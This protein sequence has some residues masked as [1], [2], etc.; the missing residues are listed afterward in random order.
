MI[1]FVLGIQA[2]KFK[3]F[4]DLVHIRRAE[5]K[6]HA[7][8]VLDILVRYITG[9]LGDKVNGSVHRTTGTNQLVCQR[10]ALCHIEERPCFI[11]TNHLEDTSIRMDEVQR[12]GGND[13][14]HGDR[15]HFDGGIVRRRGVLVRQNQIGNLNDVKLLFKADSLLH[16]AVGEQQVSKVIVRERFD[17]ICNRKRVFR[18]I[19]PQRVNDTEQ[20]ARFAIGYGT[21]R[22]S[23]DRKQLA[24]TRGNAREESQHIKRKAFCVLGFPHDD[25]RVK[26]TLVF[27]VRGQIYNV[28]LV[29]DLRQLLFPKTAF[30][31]RVKDKSLCAVQ[32]SVVSKQVERQRFTAAQRAEERTRQRIG[33]RTLNALCRPC[34]LNID[35]LVGID[36]V[37]EI[38]TIALTEHLRC[39]ETQTGKKVTGDILHI[40]VHI[41]LTCRNKFV[42]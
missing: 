3:R 4:L 2:E 23:Q 15:Q 35:I 8:I 14:Q 31:F 41:P 25:I 22:P 7:D 39:T 1:V 5:R 27:L 26:H 37:A 33:N 13:N 17:M 29:R 6:L 24:V 38:D 42:M 9:V 12:K 28:D 10:F 11:K 34:R 30:R 16:L 19:V 36:I 40:I 18:A 21:H 20:A 32:N